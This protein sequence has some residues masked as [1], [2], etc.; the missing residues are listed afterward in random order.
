MLSAKQIEAG[1]TGQIAVT[2]KTEGVTGALSKSATVF[3]N[4]PRQPLVVLTVNAIVEP[5]FGLTG[6]SIFFGSI[7]KGKEVSREVL[8]TIAPENS[9]RLTG[10]ESTDPDF[11]ARL[12]PVPDSGGKKVKL[13]VSMKPDAKEGYHAGTVVIKTS[14]PR[15]P[16]LKVAV[17][18]IVA[19]SGNH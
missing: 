11:S 9:A 18:G 4:D 10:A 8:I 3:T 5:E 15:I 14:S 19:P 6:R 1:Q 7:P 13:I 17:R 2:V 16:E 12:E